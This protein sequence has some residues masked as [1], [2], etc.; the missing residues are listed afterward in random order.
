[1]AIWTAWLS[2]LGV[3]VLL[4]LVPGRALPAVPVDDSVA[5]GGAYF[6]LAVLPVA[7]AAR[8][9][10][11]S[12]GAV[13]LAPL[14]ML[15]EVVQKVIPGRSFEWRDVAANVAGMM[16]GMALGWLLRLVWRPD[17]DSRISL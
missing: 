17:G 2:L 10:V 1:M 11:G 8:G 13:L 9:W 12:T 6:V 15:L 5:H 4:S 14:G 16:A 7:R 3:V